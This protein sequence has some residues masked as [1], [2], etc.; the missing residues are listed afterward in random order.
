[1]NDQT[2]KSAAAADSL[3][4][5]CSNGGLGAGSEP[6]KW[7]GDGL[8]ERHGLPRPK[9]Y[10]LVGDIVEVDGVIGICTEYHKGWCYVRQ[11][12]DEASWLDFIS[13]EARHGP[14]GKVWRIRDDL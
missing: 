4:Q 12:S 6:R 3:V 1:M 5:V 10:P 13:D 9:R 14:C 8:R 11:L 7:I 2:T